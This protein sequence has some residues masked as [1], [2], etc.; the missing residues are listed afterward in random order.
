[1]E[2]TSSFNNFFVTLIKST[3]KI[4]IEEK[5]MRKTNLL[6][7]LVAVALDVKVDVKANVKIGRGGGDM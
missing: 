2:L 1:K 7:N 4:L 3:N 5:K 6:S